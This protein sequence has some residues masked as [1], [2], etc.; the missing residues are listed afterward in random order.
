ML[1][2]VICVVYMCCI[3]G[4][5]SCDKVLTYMV[6]YDTVFCGVILYGMVLCDMILCHVDAV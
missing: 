5:M 2:S 6:W 4:V 1:Y 3:Y